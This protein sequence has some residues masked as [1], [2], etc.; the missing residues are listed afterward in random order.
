M[1]GVPAQVG[2]GVGVSRCGTVAVSDGVDEGVRV[3]VADGE[4]EGAVVG[5]AVIVGEDVGTM[6]KV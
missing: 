3:T 5:L 4:G 2:D 1:A 6:T